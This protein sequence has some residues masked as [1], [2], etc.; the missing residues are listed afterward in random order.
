[1]IRIQRPGVG[2]YHCV[3]ELIKKST[4]SNDYVFQLCDTNTRQPTYLNETKLVEGMPATIVKHGDVI[5][6]IGRKFRMEYPY[7]SRMRG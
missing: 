2:N 4:N 1:M 6:I 3:M 5:T 7:E